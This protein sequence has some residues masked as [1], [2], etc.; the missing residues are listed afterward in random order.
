MTLDR[1]SVYWLVLAF[2]FSVLLGAGI[3]QSNAL[4]VAVSLFGALGSLYILNEE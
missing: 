2:V 4:L 1:D 3:A